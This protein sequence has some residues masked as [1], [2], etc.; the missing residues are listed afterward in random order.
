MAKKAESTSDKYPTESELNMTPM[1]DCTFLLLI[2]FILAGKF[3]IPEG[4]LDAFLPKE[5]GP[6]GGIDQVED[7]RITLRMKGLNPNLADPEVLIEFGEQ[8]FKGED[9]ILKPGGPLR[10][11]RSK[12]GE[13]LG[14][15]IVVEP[16]VHYHWVIT[17]LNAAARAG[18]TKIS[19]SGPIPTS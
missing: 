19:F 10:D 14:L 7:V 4:R 17:A 16:K 15:V 11:I 9:L 12:Q 6:S 3:K 8:F 2:F 1:I 5:G 18:Y 13:T